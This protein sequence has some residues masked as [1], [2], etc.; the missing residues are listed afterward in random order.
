MNAMHRHFQPARMINGLERINHKDG[1]KHYEARFVQD[2]RIVHE[3]RVRHRT[4]TLAREYGKR[5]LERYLKLIEA[6]SRH[7]EPAH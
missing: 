5:V 6:E 7:A 4:A 3:S 1:S 2:R